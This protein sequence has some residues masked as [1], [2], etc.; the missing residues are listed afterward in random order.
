MK[1]L[2]RGKRHI[3]GETVVDFTVDDDGNRV[4]SKD[5][6]GKDIKPVPFV[7]KPNTAIDFDERTGAKLRRL[8]K[9]ELVTFEDL[10]RAFDG[11][12][13]ASE[14][15]PVDGRPHQNQAPA[16]APAP[17]PAAP[18]SHSDL[19]DEE[20]AFIARLRAERAQP[21]TPAAEKADDIEKLTEEELEA[22]TAP[23]KASFTD[24]VKSAL[25]GGA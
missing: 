19:S 16:P 21:L 7:L 4:Y 14:N 23:K 20:Q 2:N 13:L 15:A 24:K 11:S 9:G 5:A 3:H 1:L 22:A 17:L 25:H 12:T 18:P 8:Y 6:A 10:Q